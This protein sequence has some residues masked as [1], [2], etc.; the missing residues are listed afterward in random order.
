MA[1]KNRQLAGNAVAH[2]LPWEAALAAITS[3]AAD[4]FGIARERGRIEKGQAADLVLWSG[5]PLEVTS[6]AEQVWVAGRAV[7]MRSRQTELAQRYLE[8]LRSPQAPR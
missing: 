2:G 5:D 1:R 3:G 4:I 7:E 8:L 6:V